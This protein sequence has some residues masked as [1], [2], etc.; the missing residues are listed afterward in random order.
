MSK[1]ERR[2]PFPSRGGSQVPERVR[3]SAAKLTGVRSPVVGEIGFVGL[4]NMGKAMAANLAAAGR[5]VIA[6]VRHPDQ[7]GKLKTLGLNPTTDIGDLI[8]CEFVITMLPDDDTVREV[9]FGRS[10]D[11]LDGLAAG[12]MPGANPPIDEH[13]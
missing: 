1:H 11:V 2:S 6:Y 5:R 12:L 7:I 9:V 4:G 3:A 13:D 10:G 8:D